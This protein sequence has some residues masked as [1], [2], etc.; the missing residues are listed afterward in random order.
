MN[1]K[2]TDERPKTEVSDQPSSGPLRPWI[3]PKVTPTAIDATTK[4]SPYW[5]ENSSL[6]AS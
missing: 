2:T 3:T 1:E 6:G 5:F 4:K